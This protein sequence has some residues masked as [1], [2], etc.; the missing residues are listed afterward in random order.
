MEFLGIG[1]L[2]IM[3]ILLI[4][5]I[6][7]GPKDMAKTGRTIG[8]SLRKVV[9]SPQWR[10]ISQTSRELRNLPNRLIREAGLEDVERELSQLRETTAEIQSTLRER[11]ILPPGWDE[12]DDQPDSVQETETPPRPA[13]SIPAL[14]EQVG[15]EGISDWIT[16]PAPAGE[17]DQTIDRGSINLVAW[18]TPPDQIADNPSQSRSN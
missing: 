8:R 18:I 11:T 10:T 1:P 4:A 9:T 2:E 16:G 15:N 13:T 12:V 14:P 5:L 6:L 17:V 7:I 3:F